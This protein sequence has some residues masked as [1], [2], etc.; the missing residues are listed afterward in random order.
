MK[1][2]GWVTF[3]AIMMFIVG[4]FALL[5]GISEL[6]NS[7]WVKDV[8]MGFLGGNLF[9]MGIIDLIL[10]LAFFYA[11]YDTLKGGGF[12]YVW[13]IVFAIFSCIRWFFYI[14]GAPVMGITVIL[15]DI[16]I[17]YGLVSNEDYFNQ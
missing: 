14:W 11:G 1:R 16:L 5:A 12:G 6:T 9:W 10:A 4:G 15:I 2:P 3:A 8:S 7:S 13:G 17:I